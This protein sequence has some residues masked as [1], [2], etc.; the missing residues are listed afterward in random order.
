MKIDVKYNEL[1]QTQTQCGPFIFI[2]DGDR[3]V[4][5]EARW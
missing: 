4:N 1:E 3:I 5:F 2:R